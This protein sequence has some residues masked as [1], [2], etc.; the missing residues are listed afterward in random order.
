MTWVGV[1]LDTCLLHDLDTGADD[2]V[3]DRVDEISALRNMMRRGKLKLLLDY[4]GH[5]MSEYRAN[6]PV[7]RLGRRFVTA[8][9]RGSTVQYCSSARSRICAQKLEADSFDPSDLPFIGVAQSVG[10]FYVTTERKHL[11]DRRR[12]IALQWCSVTIAT[13]TEFTLGMRADSE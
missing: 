6:L 9:V 4:D 2:E 12:T 8:A 5:I 7:G 1:A 13:L 11:V 10:G 3:M